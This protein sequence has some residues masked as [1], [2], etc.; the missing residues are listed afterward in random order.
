[1]QAGG[2]LVCTG[3]QCGGQGVG[4]GCMRGGAAA[5]LRPPPGE[6][7]PDADTGRARRMGASVC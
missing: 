1:M 6:E 5:G 3:C 7:R 4:P 2:A